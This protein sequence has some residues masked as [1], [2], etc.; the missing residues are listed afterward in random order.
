MNISEIEKVLR[1]FKDGSIGERQV[2]EELKGAAVHSLDFAQIDQV[3][4]LRQGFPEVVF[5]EGKTPEQVAGIAEKIYRRN[6]KVLATRADETLYQFVSRQIPDLQYSEK[7]RC[8]HSPFPPEIPEATGRIAVITAGTSDIPV[9]E[10]AV[11]TCR[12]FGY[13]PHSIYDV[14][15]AGLHR[16]NNHW[17]AIGR[18]RVLIVIAGMEGALASV[19]GGLVDRPVIAVPTSVGYGTSFQGLTALFAMLNSCSSNVTVVNID[20]GFGAGFSASLILRQILDRS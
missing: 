1:K 5:C 14:G 7:A 11:V 4:E 3:R 16:L 12:L 17:E 9:A 10:E 8:I 18:A 15:V 13:T 20:N 6:G 2:L 19:I